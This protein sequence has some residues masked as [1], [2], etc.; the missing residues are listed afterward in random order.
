M[1][2]F[3]RK[4]INAEIEAMVLKEREETK[5]IKHE[6]Y[7]STNIMLASLDKLIER[8]SQ[9]TINEDKHLITDLYSNLGRIKGLL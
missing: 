7:L 6:I 5:F 9:E 1:N 3:N 8:L 4:T 2:E